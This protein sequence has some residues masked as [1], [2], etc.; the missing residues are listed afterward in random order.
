MILIRCA[1]TSPY[2]LDLGDVKHSKSNIAVIGVIW[3]Y[4]EHYFTK[5]KSGKSVLELK[6]GGGGGGS[7]LKT[8]DKFA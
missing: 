1:V 5:Q 8:F 4:N 7:T 3:L 6:G 2:E